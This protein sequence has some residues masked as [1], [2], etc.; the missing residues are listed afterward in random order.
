MS[1]PRRAVRLALSLVAAL[2][3]MLAVEEELIPELHDGDALA[4]ASATQSGTRDLPGPQH[5][6]TSTHICH[7]LHAHALAPVT[8]RSPAISGYA[9]RTTRPRDEQLPRS[10]FGEPPLRP[11]IA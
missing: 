9:V 6:P 3:L 2:G 1:S 5:S 10:A 7:C 8:T 4:I 11:P